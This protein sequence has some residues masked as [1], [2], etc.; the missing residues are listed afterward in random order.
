MS[1]HCLTCDKS[2]KIRMYGNGE[3]RLY[4]NKYEHMVYSNSTECS[5]K[6]KV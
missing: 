5:Y 2:E 3:Y 4:C 1:V 6:P